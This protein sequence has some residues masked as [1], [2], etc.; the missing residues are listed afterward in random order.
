MIPLENYLGASILDFK[1]AS[2]ENI[3]N[4]ILFSLRLYV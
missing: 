2:P 3:L 4:D 1:M